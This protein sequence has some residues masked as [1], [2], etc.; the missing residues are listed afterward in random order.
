MTKAVNGRIVPAAVLLG[1]ASLL[2]RAVGLI[3]ER[4]LTTTFGAGDTFDAFVAAF[5][6]PDLIFN[7]V[8]LGALSAS[9][10]PLF[11][12]KLVQGKRGEREAFSFALTVFN[13]VAVAVILL[14]AGYALSAPWII[15]W[16]AP[17]FTG[18]KLRL[19]VM[20]SRVMAVQPIL[21]GASFVFSGI[22]NSY[23][24]FAAYA[25]A[26]VVY[27]I[28]IIIGVV[29]LVP[30]LGV[31]GLGWGV[32]LGALL[33]LGIQVPGAVRLGF[34]WQPVI[35]WR[36]AEV[37][38]M[39]R[40]MLPRVVGLAAT[41]INL[42]VVTVIGSTLLAGSIT[43][44]H[45]ANNLQ[46]VPIGIVGI[47][48]AQA[49]FPSL[50]EHMAR[51]ERKQFRLLLAKALRYILFLVVPASL[52]M[53]LLRSQMIRVFFGDG[54]FDWADTILTYQTLGWL[55]FSIF[56]QATIPLLARAFYV[57]RDTRTPVILSTVSVAVNIAA[58]LLL[59]PFMGAPGLAAAF[60][61]AAVVN[62]G[63]LLMVLHV[64]LGG[65]D[66]KRVLISTV[67][68]A[69]ATLAG[70]VVLQ[71]LKL[72]V[73]LLVDMQRFWGVAVQMTVTSAAGWAVYIGVTWR[74]GSEELQALKKYMPRRFKPA[75]AAGHDT[76][77]FES[78]SD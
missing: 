29:Y 33:H 2:S 71:L 43:A 28:G 65:L 23:K 70:G 68:I 32:V 26:P 9:F 50:A 73:A 1:L 19:T 78:L 39:I 5:R 40:M 25:L 37:R 64:R 44:F 38:E 62:M 27:N 16:L 12:D 67:K 75:L 22:L 74:L 69:A 60:S 54:A 58:A 77:R 14:S 48:F 3:R 8:V 59:S 63:L 49:A 72:P 56:A 11:T 53:Y 66:D 31:T 18:D 76:P 52:Y 42:L 13:I 57:Q 41:Q 17:G 4:V 24:R 20:L 34:R 6:V 51:G 7:L 46:H 47:A 15:H 30:R 45:L 10:I 35:A 36:S 21:L 55:T 61:L